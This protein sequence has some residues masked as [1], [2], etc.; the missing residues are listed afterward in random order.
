LRILRHDRSPTSYTQTHR[1][2]YPSIPSYTNH[3]SSTVPEGCQRRPA[4]KLIHSCGKGSE[5]CG[6]TEGRGCRR[7]CQF[8]SHALLFYVPRPPP[9][10]VGWSEVVPAYLH[11][12]GDL[13]YVC[14]S[15][16]ATSTDCTC[17]IS[18]SSPFP[19]ISDDFWTTLRIID[20]LDR[21]RLQLSAQGRH[22]QTM[23]HL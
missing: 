13:L 2:T 8:L 3:L 5:L 9:S 11:P 20:S 18:L 7:L 23:N 10:N 15:S 21:S 1:D 22:A 12:R 19:A 14:P 16:H 4:P 6:A 17:D